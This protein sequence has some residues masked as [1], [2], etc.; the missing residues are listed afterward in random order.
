MR[1]FR[2]I[3]I[4]MAMLSLL[5]AA[6]CS[7][8][9]TTPRTFAM[10]DRVELGHIIYTVFETQ[11]MTQIGSGLDA[12]IPQ[13][14]FFLVR[15]SAANSGIAEVMV[16]SMTV[17]DDDGKAYAELTDGDGVPNWLGILR[18]AKPAEAAQGDVVF[19]VPPRRYKLRLVDENE[20]KTAF[21]DLP[22]AFAPDT[23]DLPLPTA[24]E[25]PPV[26]K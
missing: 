9:P 18:R 14:R 22:L 16:P 6:G 2:S 26:R 8:A 13:N 20:Q 11:W 1:P 19:D 21:V 7:S 24:K 25:P 17:V 12:R 10:G 4:A 5:L 3:L 23:P 15:L